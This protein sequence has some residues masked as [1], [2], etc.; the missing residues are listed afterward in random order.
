MCYFTCYALG[1]IIGVLVAY[2]I[3]RYVY[4][5]DIKSDPDAM[6]IGKL[7]IYEGRDRDR[8]SFAFDCPLDQIS[9]FKKVTLEVKKKDE[10]SL[11]DIESDLFAKDFN[12]NMD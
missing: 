12:P 4:T 1:F 3:M 11:R 9:N 10:K 8:Y 5:R 2:V 6:G 7:Y